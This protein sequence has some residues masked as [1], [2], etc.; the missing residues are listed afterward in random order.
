MN[1]RLWIVLVIVILNTLISLLYLFLTFYRDKRSKKKDGYHDRVKTWILFVVMLLCVGVG[2]LFVGISFLLRHTIF[3]NPVDLDDVVFAKERAITRHPADTE[4]ERNM[5]PMEEALAVS[6]KAGLRMLM[7]NVLK[8]DTRV[9]LSSISKALNS[10]DTETAHY[11]A[12]VLRDELNLFRSTVQSKYNEFQEKSAD[13]MVVKGQQLIE[14]MNAFLMQNVFTPMEQQSYVDL[15]EQVATKLYD[16]EHTA[17]HNVHYE[18]LCMRLLDIRAMDR[19][20]L[21]CQRSMEVYPEEL[22]CY[23]CMLRY[24]F[25][26]GD[27]EEFMKTLDQLKKTDIV[28]NN[29]ILELIRIF[30]N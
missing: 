29:E 1:T 7:M 26:K 6:D 16:Y 8:G 15:M 10:S 14:Y 30:S 11:A 21:W 17:L 4:R 25:Q 9:F 2:P 18:Y 27:R 20:G 12:T 22:S 19:C 3:N 23:T 5:A 13:G 24:E 28:I